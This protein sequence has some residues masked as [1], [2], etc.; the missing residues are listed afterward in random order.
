MVSEGMLPN[1]FPDAGDA[2]EFNAV[3]A[4]LWYVVAAGDTVTSVLAGSTVLTT[5]AIT[6]NAATLCSTLN[7]AAQRNARMATLVAQNIADDG[8]GRSHTLFLYRK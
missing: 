2:P 8:E 5:A 7:T 4:S 6:C 3:D 1:R